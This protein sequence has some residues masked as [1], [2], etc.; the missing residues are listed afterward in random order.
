MLKKIL[1]FLTITIMTLSLTS[2]NL[3]DRMIE[4]LN[5]RTFIIHYNANGGTGEM[6]DS[7][8]R[9]DSQS[10]FPKCKFTNEGYE[11]IGWSLDPE[12]THFAYSVDKLV[13]KLHYYLRDGDTINL[14]AIWATPG[15][16]FE[17]N[18]VAYFV[19]A[20]TLSY[21]GNSKHVIV[22]AW[23]DSRVDSVGFTH[24]RVKNTAPKLFMDHTEIET[25]VNVPFTY[26][27][28]DLFNG[29]TSLRTIEMHKNIKIEGIGKR[30]F[31]NCNN[32]Q[33]IGSISNLNKIGDEAFYM[34]TSIE[35]LVITTKLEN[36]GKNVF[37]GWTERQTIEFTCYSSNPFGDEW[38][39][40]CNAT[41]IWSGK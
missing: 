41:I 20:R 7:V 6:E 12:G 8:V 14:Y 29:C 5:S 3:V 33:N 19:S 16:S 18:S 11:C 25:I 38:L 34:C 23:Y 2:C 39:N 13:S 31:Y 36:I 22:P 24:Y 40:G 4:R 17:I 37:Y 26:Y 27:S 15:F 1:L 21:E 32:L 30:A 28:D 10:S 35:K 9:A